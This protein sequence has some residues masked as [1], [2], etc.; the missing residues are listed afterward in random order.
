MPPEHKTVPT[1]RGGVDLVAVIRPLAFTQPSRVGIVGVADG[2]IRRVT[3]IFLAILRQHIEDLEGMTCGGNDAGIDNSPFADEQSPAFQLMVA[4]VQQP[5]EAIA[6]HQALA[7]T[8]DRGGV[9]H[10]VAVQGKPH[11]PDKG[12]AIAQRLFHRHVA[13]V[14]P[15]LEQEGLEHEKWWVG[16]VADGIG[17]TLELLAKHFFERFPVDEAIDLV[18]EAILVLAA[19]G[20]I[21]CNTGLLGS[22]FAHGRLH[23]L[24]WREYTS[25]P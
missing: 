3:G 8:A 4:F 6:L 22:A 11:E 1:V 21:V 15:P 24:G 7:E 18:Q 20:N 9:R 10:L 19:S 25:T 2:H 14:A 23:L 12:Q 5:L 13:E 16:R 17:Y